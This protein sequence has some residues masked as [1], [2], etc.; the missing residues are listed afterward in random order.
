MDE[1]GI[2]TNP[3]NQNDQKAK[4]IY[5][6]SIFSLIIT[7]TEL[8]IYPKL[9]N[10]LFMSQIILGTFFVSTS[11]NLPEHIHAPASHSSE[12][13]WAKVSSWVD[14]ISSSDSLQWP[15]RP[16]PQVPC[17]LEHPCSSCQWCQGCT[18]SDPFTLV[19][20]CIKPCHYI[21]PW[22]MRWSILWR[23]AI[24]VSEAVAIYFTSVMLVNMQNHGFKKKGSR[25]NE[26][27]MFMIN[28]K[29]TEKNI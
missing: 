16:C 19:S 9:L 22:K 21:A 25:L 10:S 8:R 2:P 5:I 7:P 23:L 11:L 27:K 24:K 29:K 12:E 28:K 14:G 20:V 3:F 6:Y 1:V 26:P 13:P 4:I 15:W 18:G 17:L